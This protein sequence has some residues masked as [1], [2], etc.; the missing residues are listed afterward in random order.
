MG[1]LAHLGLASAH[2]LQGD[3]A[4]ARAAHVETSQH[5][6]DAC[7]YQALTTAPNIKS[8]DWPALDESRTPRSSE[9]IRGLGARRLIARVVEA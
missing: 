9:W 7:V 4:K 8:V 3:T 5:F 2:V 1:A 6:P